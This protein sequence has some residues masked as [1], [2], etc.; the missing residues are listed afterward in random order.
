VKKKKRLDRWLLEAMQ[1]KKGKAVLPKS[2]PE[3]QQLYF[4]SISR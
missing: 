2:D 1:T 4:N 3:I